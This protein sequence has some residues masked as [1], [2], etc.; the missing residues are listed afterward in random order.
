MDKR[1][2][3]SFNNGSA[4]LKESDSNKSFVKKVQSRVSGLLSTSL[5]K[6]FG[7]N[8]GQK[9]RLRDEDDDDETYNIQPPSKR[10]KMPTP[11]TKNTY[12]NS[13]SSSTYTSDPNVRTS[14]YTNNTKIFE[15][16]AGPSGVQPNKP[17]LESS[18]S[19]DN[20]LNGDKD[21]ESEE[22][23]D[24]YSSLLRFNHANDSITSPLNRDIKFN[25]T[26]PSTG[27]NRSLFSDRSSMSQLNTSLSSRRPSFNASTF[28]SPNFVD[29]TLS[30]KR[31]LNSPFYKGRTIYGGASAYSA[32]NRNAVERQ[33]IRNQVQVTPVNN[34]AG[35]DASL[36][37]T[38]RRIL[39]ALEE[40]RSPLSDAHKVPAPTKRP[41]PEGMLS[42]YAGAN[43]YIKDHK[44]P[45]ALN[46]ELQVPTVPDLLKMKLKERLQ[47]ST[48]A[49]RQIATTSK[50]A[51]NNDD[52]KIRTEEETPKHSNKIKN[53]ITATRQQKPDSQVQD[54][55]LPDIALPITTLPKFDF[56]LPPPPSSSKQPLV[57]VACN[58][59][60]K[61]T[62]TTK[63][64]DEIETRTDTDNVYKFSNPLVLAENLISIIA[65]NDFKFSDPVF[66][67]KDKEKSPSDMGVNFK[68]SNENIQLKRKV[69]SET[70]QPT[71]KLLKSSVDD[72]FRKTTP[73]KTLDKFKPAPETWECSV[74]LIRN[75]PE[76]LKCAACENPKPQST[77][78]LE[79]AKT[80]FGEQF[81]MSAEKWECSVCMVRNSNNDLKCV[82]CSN[83]KPVK[84]NKINGPLVTCNPPIPTG[85]G[86][87]DK[88]KLPS[89]VWICPTCMIQN[90]NEIEK[91]AACETQKPGTKSVKSN[92]FGDAFKMKSSE[93]ECSICMIRNPKEKDACVA[94]ET[95]KPGTKPS[96]KIEKQENIPTFNFGILPSAKNVTKTTEVKTPAVIPSLT[97]ITPSTSSSAIP[98]FTFGIPHKQLTPAV[99]PATTEATQVP[100]QPPDNVEVTISKADK[101]PENKTPKTLTIEEPVKPLVQP[102]PPKPFVASG[103]FTFENFSKPKE[104]APTVLTPAKSTEN[105]FSK[106]IIIPPLPT[107]TFNPS[108]S[109]PSLKRTLN[110]AD[111]TTEAKKEAVITSPSSIIF[112]P[113]KTDSNVL[114]PP[115]STPHLLGQEKN[116]F[117]S[118]A[119]PQTMVLT[120]QQPAPANNSFS[121]TTPQT[122]PQITSTVPVNLFS[123]GAK[124]TASSLFG[125]T[126]TSTTQSPIFNFNQPETANTQPTFGVNTETQPQMSMFGKPA[127]SIFGKP[128]FEPPSFGVSSSGFG[129]EIK[130]NAPS[131]FGGEMKQ[132]PIS[133]FGSE[134]K[135]PFGS[136]V[137]QSTAPPAFGSD[138]KTSLAPPAFGSTDIK[139]FTFRT[140]TNEEASKP[141]FSFGSAPAKPLEPAK[142]VT[143]N[144]GGS[145]NQPA[146]PGGFSFSNNNNAANPSFNFSGPKVEATSPFQSPAPTTNIFNTPLQP[147]TQPLQNGGFNFGSAPSTNNNMKTGFNFGATNQFNAASGAQAPPGPGIFS[148]GSQPNPAPTPA[149]GGFNFGQTAPPPSAFNANMK[150]NFN[151]TAGNLPA[152]FSATSDSV[153]TAQRRKLKAVRRNQR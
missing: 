141:L 97:T 142:P 17:N 15:P 150:P 67:Q 11:E 126:T 130:P 38:A 94:C 73:E 108:T 54:V 85:N 8:D 92:G 98:T 139:P 39:H 1:D 135:Q 57:T 32:Q 93:W 76:K 127:T 66:K 80:C 114:K 110:D 119:K 112:S 53:K 146:A 35:N 34:S 123:F 132:H 125:N 133:G 40:F 5:S 116:V 101:P 21:S 16:V 30:T 143:F 33:S 60:T 63:N 12:V 24:G 47:D 51:L 70:P 42:K 89:S 121:F 106:P 100:Q 102:E 14:D 56:S 103:G 25:P 20:L 124:T 27:H 104:E 107:F 122:Q 74:C 86:F 62:E 115:V 128:V 145:S 152:T 52:Y 2:N 144:F 69:P 79:P 120:T 88:F 36:S 10:I 99:R 134:I 46:K 95:P 49:V 138:M 64:S 77:Q 111:S 41:R 105:S 91:C 147:Q 55:K 113:P 84:D 65:I 71:V 149:A 26:P 75:V 31:I 68:T 6:W 87:G 48:V 136:D 59:A 58:E 45:L 3:F 13:Y 43:P 81:K 7:G 23:T 151:F 19:K 137:K 82:A 96:A 18:L 117:G 37:E 78:K 153:V 148:F 50:S 90:K 140:S 9:A 44:I 118:I 72:V 29:R 22:S 109:A 28:G 129:S 131:G 4:L 83:S 61:V